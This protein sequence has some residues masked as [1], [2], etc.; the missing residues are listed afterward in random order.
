MGYD[1]Y[2]LIVADFMAFSKRK[3]ILTGPGRGSSD[4][5]LVAYSLQITQVDPLV[6]S[7]GKG[8]GSYC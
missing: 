1:S 6:L 3:G 2:F 8:E 4:S 5:S 7:I